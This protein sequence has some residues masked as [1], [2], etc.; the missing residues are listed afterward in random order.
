MAKL[1]SKRKILYQFTTFYKKDFAHA[2]YYSRLR[3]ISTVPSFILK[4]CSLQVSLC[5]CPVCILRLLYLE[6]TL[7][8]DQIELALPFERRRMLYIDT[9]SVPIEMDFPCY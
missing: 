6:R 5:H 8:L 2:R 4:P 7:H 9:P 3:P 1:Y